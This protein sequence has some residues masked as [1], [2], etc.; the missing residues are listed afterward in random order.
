V[1]P[2]ASAGPSYP[3]VIAEAL[4]RFGSREAFIEGGQRLSY[5]R[6]AEIVSQFQQVLHEAGIGPGAT[7][8][9]LSPNV[10]EVFL[11]QVAA[12]L[13]GARYSGLHPLGSVEDH[14]ALCDDAG[15]SVLLAHPDYAETAVAVAGGCPAV[16]TVLFLGDCDAGQNLLT[17]AAAFAPRQLRPPPAQAADTVWMVYTGGTTGRSKAV[18]HG[19]R[20]MVQ[21][22]LGIASAWALPQTPR[23]LACGPITHASVLPVVP[24]LARGGTVV[25]NRGFDPERW[26]DTI[27]RERVNYSFIVPTM[28]YTLLDRCDPRRHD[29]SSLQSVVYGSAPASATRVAEALDALGPI[30]TQGYGQSETLGL[31]TVLRADEH[32]PAGRP[33]LL[34]SCGRAVPGADIA[35][36]DDDCDEVADGVVGELCLRAGFVMDGYWNRPALTEEALRGGWLHT[37]DMAARRDD[38]FLYIVD[39]KKDMIISGAFNIYPRD[40]EEVL[41]ADPAVSAAAVIGV[42]DPK[43][44]EAV[45]AFVVARPGARVDAERLRAAVR[46]RKG[47]HQVPKQIHEVAALPVTNLGK[48][49]KKALRAPFW[50]GNARAVN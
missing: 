41:A 16:R 50:Q 23:Y 14:I 33:E 35:I 15:A 43:W 24:T 39:R 10:P 1:T 19:H 28:L 48:V 44:G 22:M 4:A 42:P 26:L 20:S 11:A 8:V 47:A 37:G 12:W 7:V 13:N 38:G 18:L 17:R 45:T 30:L 31:A 49:D 9:A 3:R 32:D 29:L 36:L 2:D 5:A 40:V 25:L 27:T 21:G 6:C 34:S 46:A